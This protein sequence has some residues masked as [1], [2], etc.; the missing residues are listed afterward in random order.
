MTIGEAVRLVRERAGHTQREM[1]AAL[2]I[3][4]VHVCYVERGRSEPSLALLRL[5]REVYG[6]DPAALAFLSTADAATLR[7]HRRLA[8][9]TGS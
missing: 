3:T 4:H 8:E 9:E 6:Y 1:G 5:F 2:G 7:E